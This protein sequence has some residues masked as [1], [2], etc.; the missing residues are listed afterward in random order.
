MR[1]GVEGKFDSGEDVSAMGLHS[2]G[3]VYRCGV[4]GVT[5]MKSACEIPFKGGSR[6]QNWSII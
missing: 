1:M 6:L 4:V 5:D 3:W 2:T